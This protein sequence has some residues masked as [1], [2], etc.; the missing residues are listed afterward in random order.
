[1]FVYLSSVFFLEDILCAILYNIRIGG[2]FARLIYEWVPIFRDE[3]YGRGG[4]GG[5]GAGPRAMSCRTYVP[6][7]PLGYS[8]ETARMYQCVL[9]I[10]TLSHFNHILMTHHK[11][12]RSKAN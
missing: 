8:P 4:G 10:K 9:L 5:A 6:K 12:K 3:V 7:S 2:N 11:L 1:M